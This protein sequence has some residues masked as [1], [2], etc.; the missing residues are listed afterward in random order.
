MVGG[1][2]SKHEEEQASDAFSDHIEQGFPTSALLCLGLDVSLLQGCGPVHFDIL[3]SFPGLSQLK[4]VAI[5]RQTSGKA[6]VPSIGMKKMHNRYLE[7][8]ERQEVG[9]E[10]WGERGRT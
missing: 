7:K 2:R 8:M 3:T 10:K 4:V 5:R 1:S 9:E 6:H